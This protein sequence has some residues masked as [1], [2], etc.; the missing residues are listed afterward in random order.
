M[1]R[2][3]ILLIITKAGIYCVILQPRLTQLWLSLNVGRDFEIQ[4]LHIIKFS[5]HNYLR[6]VTTKKQ[7]VIRTDT[8]IVCM[9]TKYK[10]LLFIAIVG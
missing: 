2:E 3:R 9:V 5:H 4:Y 7:K 8:R 10:L 1:I 6:N